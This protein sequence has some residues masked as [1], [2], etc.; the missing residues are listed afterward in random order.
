MRTHRLLVAALA[1]VLGAST[2]LAAGIKSGPQV[3]EKL[4][5][6]FHPL[7]INGENAGQKHCLYCQN[8]D[9]PVA[10]VFA[11]EVTPETARLIKAI[12][13]A[14]TRNKDSMGSFVVFLGKNEELEKK[15]KDLVKENN[16]KT[17]ILA[18]DNPGGPEGYKVARDADVTV[19]LYRERTVKANHA[20]KRGELKDSGIKAVVADLPKILEK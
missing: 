9:R 5:G 6:P 4:A 19:V 18:I 14:N 17:T 11:R 2:A 7:N 3:D 13:A 12:D 16:I 8:G 20:F 10:M 15:L 1:L